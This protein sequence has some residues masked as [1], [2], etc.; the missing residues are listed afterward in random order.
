ML[1]KVEGKDT[2]SVVSALSRQVRKLPAE[3]RKSLI[4][5]RGAEMARRKAFALATNVDVYFC[6]PQNPWPCGS[7]ENTNGLSRQYFPNSTDLSGHSQ[8]YLNAIARHLD[9][10]PRKTL[11]FKTP[12]DKLSQTAATTR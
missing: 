2:H 7:N 1:V 8:G 12:A 10:R 9:E 3:L 4:W 6:D 11:D 5:G